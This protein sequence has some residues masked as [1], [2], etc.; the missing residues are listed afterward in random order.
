[1]R[2]YNEFEAYLDLEGGADR[3]KGGSNRQRTLPCSA[4]TLLAAA[5]RWLPSTHLHHLSAQGF[6]TALLPPAQQV[7]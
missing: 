6:R 1:M 7:M 2:L 4:V 3:S 5:L